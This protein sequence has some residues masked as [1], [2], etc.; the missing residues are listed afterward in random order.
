M[1]DLGAAARAGIPVANVPDFCIDEVSTQ[2][3]GF[4]IDFHRRTLPLNAHV[5]AG[6]W[7]SPRPVTPP[8][9]LAGQVGG[10]VG[11]GA[12]GRA[13]DAKAEALGVRVLAHDPYADGAPGVQMVGLD[14]LLAQA[15]YVS[16]HCPLT[17]ETRGLIG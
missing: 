7:G 13:V 6:R 5:H 4:R 11:L 10:I 15:D 2:T 3:I 14:D 12:I 8:R 9:R 16:L 17:D 1:I